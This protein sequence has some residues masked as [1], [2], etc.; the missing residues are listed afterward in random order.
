M[1]IREKHADRFQLFTIVTL[2]I[3]FKAREIDQELI[4]V[5]T[6]LTTHTANK[7]KLRHLNHI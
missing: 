4:I 2:T 5:C 3:W 1:E 7:R 6:N